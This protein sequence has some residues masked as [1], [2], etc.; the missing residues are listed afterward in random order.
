MF[1]I[2]LFTI[3]Y[4]STNSTTN[5]INSTYNERP[6]TVSSTQTLT[7]GNEKITFYSNGNWSGTDESTYVSGTYK[8]ADK[9]KIYLYPTGTNSYLE[10]RCI[11]TYVISSRTWRINQIIFNGY[12]YK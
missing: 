7:Y 11:C 3:V 2:S 10:C 6:T 1:V 5:S 9:N 8:I 4:A 12:T